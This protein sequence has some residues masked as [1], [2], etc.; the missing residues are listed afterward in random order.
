MAVLHAEAPLSASQL[1]KATEQMP[2][3]EL[4]RFLAEVIALRASQRAP[5]LSKTESAL[6]TGI[7]QGTPRDLQQRYD[8][9]VAKRR[10]G[11]LTEPDHNELLRLSE[12]FE[13][14]DLARVK[15]LAELARIRKS[16]LSAVMADLEIEPPPYV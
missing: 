8:E 7:N 3:A 10:E 12:Q 4:E 2:E 11:L 14:R 13:E 6:L 15:L 9:L 16:T 1:L 5:S